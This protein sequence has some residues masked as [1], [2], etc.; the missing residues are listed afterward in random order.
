MKK[1]K[2]IKTF[3][4]LVELLVVLTII[5]LLAGILMPGL[6]KSRKEALKKNCLSNLRQLAIAVKIYNQEHGYY[7]DA[8][9][10]E[11]AGKI[12][13][14]CAEFNGNNANFANSPLAD[15]IKNPQLLICPTF[16]NFR[17]QDPSK[18]AVCSYGINAEFV[19][20]KPSP[21]ANIN[22]ILNNP[23][24][25]TDEIKKTSNVVLFADS[26]KDDSGL[27]ES[28]LV[29]ARYSYEQGFELD[30]T[31]HFRHDNSASAV[32]CDGHA[33]DTLKPDAVKNESLKLGWLSA[34]IT[35]VY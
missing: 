4:S 33:E 29:W 10:D 32:F 11:G 5:V 30:S 23:P 2:K 20:G 1:N 9:L 16:T 26:A 22:Q 27:T 12:K 6:M 25:L 19:G 8:Y 28:F 31:T 13:Y 15:Y 34:D 7:P 18:P 21:G 35:Q 3:F 14:W 24:P 17:S